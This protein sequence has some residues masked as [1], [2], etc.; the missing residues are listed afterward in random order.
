MH[1]DFVHWFELIKYWLHLIAI[2]KVSQDK[3]QKQ[4]KERENISRSTTSVYPVDNNS[5]YLAVI[6]RQ[7]VI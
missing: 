2:R 6:S 3:Q 7:W 5:A 1:R 4:K